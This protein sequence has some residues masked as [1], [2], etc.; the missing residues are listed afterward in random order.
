MD[1]ELLERL[2]AV[3]GAFL[4]GGTPLD[5]VLVSVGG[6]LEA[7]LPIKGVAVLEELVQQDQPESETMLMKPFE[8]ENAP[9][10]PRLTNPHDFVLVSGQRPRGGS[11]LGPLLEE[12]LHGAHV[13]GADGAVQR[14]HPVRVHALHPRP[15]VQQKLQTKFHSL[16][17][18]LYS[19]SLW[20]DPFILRTH[21]NN[22][23]VAFVCGE[24]EGRAAFLVRPVEVGALVEQA[25][26]RL[27]APLQAR[28]AERGHSVAVSGVD[29][30]L[31]LRR[32]KES[33]NDEM[34]LGL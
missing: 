8:F 12:A 16:S 26:R 33:R 15:A 21:L 10:L 25:L 28:P 32:D 24:E 23:G 31:A 5:G 34:R 27:H 18:K 20:I 1:L 13:S 4:F 7:V 9:A 6:L 17:R 30:S 11:Q 22:F 3:V 19:I 2:L 29:Q 14:P